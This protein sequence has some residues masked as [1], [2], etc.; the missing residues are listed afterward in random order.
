MET[1]VVQS[2]NN[3]LFILVGNIRCY[4]TAKTLFEAGEQAIVE[5]T[6]TRAVIKDKPTANAYTETWQAALPNPEPKPKHVH[7]GKEFVLPD[8]IEKEIYFIPLAVM[9]MLW[10]FG[11]GCFLGWI[12]LK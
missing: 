3:G 2:D 8:L 6:G 10:S 9:L 5:I 1:F 4:P 11:I 7:V 12:L